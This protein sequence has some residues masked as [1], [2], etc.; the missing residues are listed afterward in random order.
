MRAY[1]RYTQLENSWSALTSITYPEAATSI[2]ARE[3]LGCLFRAWEK[4]VGEGDRGA[5]TEQKEMIVRWSPPLSAL[6]VVVYLLSV[7][8]VDPFPLTKVRRV[9]ITRTRCVPARL[10]YDDAVC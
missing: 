6:F 3:H 10:L 4:S 8:P 1:A 2:V 7:E 9:S 5:K